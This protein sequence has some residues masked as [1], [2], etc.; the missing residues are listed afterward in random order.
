MKP[1]ELRNMTR[2][3]LQAKERDLRQ[4]LLN[5]RLQQQSG[6]IQKPSRIRELRRDI[7][8]LKTILNERRA[9]QPD[10]MSKTIVVR[11]A[12]RVRH[13]RYDKVITKTKKFYAHDPQEKA[14]KGD[15]VR[16]RETRP[17]SR[18]KRW[19]LVEIIKAAPAGASAVEQNTKAT[20]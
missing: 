13:P 18:L 14:A 5:L 12:R 19:E 4:E 8:R 10:A 6:Q 1:K 2:E 11:V 20:P 7:A 15:L 17:L 16:I 3:E 9:A